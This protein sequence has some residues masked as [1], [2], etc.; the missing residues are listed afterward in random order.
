MPYTGIE[1]LCE[2]LLAYP[3]SLRKLVLRTHPLTWKK[4]GPFEGAVAHAVAHSEVR[5]L[6][7]HEQPVTRAAHF[8]FQFLLVLTCCIYSIIKLNYLENVSFFQD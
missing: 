6:C 7:L 2:Q 1:I 3:H 5:E 8:K 4:V